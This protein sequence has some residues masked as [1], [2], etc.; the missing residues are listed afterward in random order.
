MLARVTI[1]LAN[2]HRVSKVVALELLGGRGD[3]AYSQHHGHNEHQ[4]H[5]FV[6]DYGELVQILHHAV[7]Y[8]ADGRYLLIG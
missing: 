3:K 8:S 4:L 2:S 7:V 6:E 5:N 1:D